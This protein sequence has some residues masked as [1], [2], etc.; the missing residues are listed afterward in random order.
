[1]RMFSRSRRGF[2]LIELMVALVIL[3]ILMGF[4]IPEVIHQIESSKK[5]TQQQN[6]KAI[7]KALQ[8]FFADHG[9]YPESLAALVN[10]THPYFE[11][12]PI[13]PITGR[14]DTWLITSKTNYV[15]TKKFYTQGDF[16][17]SDTIHEGIYRCKAKR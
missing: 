17:A 2:T 10:A 15:A 12:I 1:M 7:N 8:D 4:A 11:E 9:R 3:S 13:D 14:A 16:P 5:Q 6:E